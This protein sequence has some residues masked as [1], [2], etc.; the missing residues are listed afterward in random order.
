MAILGRIREKSF[1]LI[2]LIALGLVLFLI[3]PGKIMDFVNNGGGKQFVAKVG[4]EVV[5]VEDFD[6]QVKAQGGSQNQ[7]QA[8]N[9]VYD[10]QIENI[11]KKAEFDKLGIRVEK[12]QMW[13]LIKSQ[14][15]YNPEF[16]AEDGTLDE[17][18]IKELIEQRVA[19]NP[20]AWKA[21]EENIAIS[22]QTQLY[23]AMLKAASLPTEKAGELAY[24]MENDLIDMKYVYLPYTSIA[25]STIT[26]SK[27]KIQ[28]YINAHKDEFKQEANRSIQFVYF[29]EKPSKED[30]DAAKAKM[31]KNM[32]ALKAATGEKMIALVEENS[33]TKYD[34]IY[35]L[36]SAL[37]QPIQTE[38]DSMQI[39][40]VFGPYVMGDFTKVAKLTGVKMDP[41]VKASHILIA[42]EGA[43]RANPEVKRTKEEA[44]AEANR[45]LAEVKGSDKEF[46][47]FAK[48]NSDGPSKTKGGD[49]GW[50][51]EGQMVKEF[52]DYVFNNDKGSIGL[53]ET[54]FG[55][56]I[57]KVVDTKEEK[58]Y[59]LATIATKVEASQK[60]L[61]NLY[62]DATAFEVAVG[63]GDFTKVA[64]D[65]KY[66]L[67]PVNKV[68]ELADNLPGLQGS[69]RQIVKWMFDEDTKVGDVRR[70]DVKGSFV[71]VQ[72]TEKQAEGL[73][74]TDEASA[75]VLP[76]LRK[77]VKAKQLKDKIT[78]TVLEDIA[79]NNNT[80]VKTANA[81]S[82]SNPTIPGAGREP[83]VVGTAFALESGQTSGLIEGEKGIYKVEVTKRTEAPKLDSYKMYAK[84]TPANVSGVMKALKKK[85]EI[86]DNRS[87]YY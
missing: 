13:D 71:V 51:N 37:D 74:S 8:V 25:D 86:E 45:L 11:L 30:E 61:E 58:K 54:D 26:I 31:L 53:V 39:G 65:K 38:V 4:D 59:Q 22:G 52:N 28:S 40:D 79:K 76:I 70:F 14:F 32:E 75:T 63:S 35:K 69:Q 36:V 80:N 62:N 81:L 84:I 43:T 72:L 83:L 21:T 56:H 33:E 7:M 50:F 3:D 42:Y 64:E 47:E 18:K 82:L 19:E 17:G 49:L 9:R 1:L 57:I 68:V 29:E 87:R 10:Q 78:S 5:Y 66:Q 2:I 24:K 44:K 77:E 20:A 23:T 6:R 67:R 27:D 12:D 55:F 48:E 16:K 85:V 46:A 41:S 73:M 60:T 34:S 15:T